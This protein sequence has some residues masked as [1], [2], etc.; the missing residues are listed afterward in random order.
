VGLLLLILFGFL[1]VFAPLVSPYDPN[2]VNYDE[3]LLAP[4]AKH[5]FGT[6]EH[7]RD[8]FSR[9]IFGARISFL[10]AAV[11]VGLATVIGVPLGLTAGYLG[12]LYDMVT[13]RILD[14]VFAFPAV[15]MALFITVLLGPSEITAMIAIG[16]VSIP[17]FARVSR[18]AVLS[19]KENTYVEAAKSVGC[20]TPR[21]LVRTILPNCLDPL[22]VL[23]SL[24]FGYAVLNEA[25]LSFL[26]IGAQPPTPSWG[27]TLA[28]G[29]RYLFE[30]PWYSIFPGLAIFLL[31]VSANLIGDGLRDLADPRS[32]KG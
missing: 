9:V 8:L 1:A 31:V 27:I 18:S 22:L 23:I 32:R 14:G 10:I 24:G 7:G 13:G 3:T 5:L 19:V 21:T 25:A 2:E 26:G 17:E 12:G 28:R 29:R 30:A 16:I 11:S 15:L 6:D 4:N 20:P